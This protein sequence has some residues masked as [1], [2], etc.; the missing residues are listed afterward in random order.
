MKHIAFTLF[1]FALV[2][3]SCAGVRAQSNTV[4]QAQSDALTNYLHNNML[5]LVGAE[6]SDGSDGSHRVMLYGFVATDSAAVTAGE[7]SLKYLGTP[8]LTLIN[9]IKVDTTISSSVAGATGPSDPASGAGPD[10]WGAIMD[11]IYQEG[12]QTPPA[13]GVPTLP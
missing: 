2:I 9:R 3:A 8:A 6:V 7:I 11:D 12:A 1:V 10:S 4:D 5:P 13:Q